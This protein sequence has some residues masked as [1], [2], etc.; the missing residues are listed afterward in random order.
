MRRR[1]VSSALRN[2]R[3]RSERTTSTTSLSSSVPS[4][5]ARLLHSTEDDE[6]AR[7]RRRKEIEINRLHY[8]AK[9]RGFLELDVVVGEW[10]ERNLAS[11]SDA[12]LE[13][14]AKVLEEENPDLYAW[15]TGQKEAP[16]RMA[17]ENEAYEELRKHVHKF[18]DEKSDVKTRA[19][20]GKEWVRGWRDSGGGNQ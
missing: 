15:L 2:A 6:E 3:R 13:Q 20:H 16:E 14:F 8:R 12:F 17:K 7:R 10:A 11:K 9:Q 18:L 4:S 19:V 5:R 1:L